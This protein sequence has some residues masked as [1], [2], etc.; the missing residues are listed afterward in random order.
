[1]LV[2]I[3]MKTIKHRTMVPNIM[4]R[5]TPASPPALKQMWSM[6]VAFDGCLGLTKRD[7]QGQVWWSLMVWLR[8]LVEGSMV[9]MIWVFSFNVF[10]W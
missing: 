3:P 9:V 6:M 10:S 5:I 8:V 1:M 4:P 2:A 7:E